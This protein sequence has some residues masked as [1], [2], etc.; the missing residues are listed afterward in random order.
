[1][2][3]SRGSVA[4]LALVAGLCGLTSAAGAD[5]ELMF[6]TV[7]YKEKATRV[8][9]PMLDGRFDAGEH[10][11]VDAHLLI[12][13]ISSASTASSADAEPFDET[14]VEV[15]TGYTHTLGTYQLGG[16]ARY[17]T[18]PDYK[19]VYGTIRGQA[20][21]FERNLTLGVTLGRGHDDINALTMPVGELESY[22]AS[23]SVAQ[24][25]SPDTI[26]SLTYDLTYLSGYQENPY[27]RVVQ[28]ASPIPTQVGE[29]VPDQRTRHALAATVRRFYEPTST[30]LVASYRYYFDDWGVRAQTPEVRVIQDA[31]DTMQVSLRYR[32]H[33][34]R[35][36]EFYQDSY[37]MDAVL[38][39]DDQKLSTFDA[40]TIT[41]KFA[42]TGATFGFADRLGSVIGELLVEY[43]IVHNDFGN[44]G[45]AHAALTIP[46][47]Y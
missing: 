44:A 10:G 11:S 23:A 4:A 17:S 24:I 38:L 2:Q 13:A 9:Q 25:L 34:Q 14:R 35:A 39:T 7:Y 16:S 22:L 32:Y 19:S 30:T 28:A 29:N 43:N 5:G 33:H 26:A 20:E 31:G 45:V 37:P 1:V 27:R 40:H 21:L 18:E 8:E 47:E 42:V 6:R 36:A 41:M 15:G 3:L 46:F 12:D